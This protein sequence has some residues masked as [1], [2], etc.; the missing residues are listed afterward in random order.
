L[1]DEKPLQELESSTM[2][3]WPALVVD[4]V[5]DFDVLDDTPPL[6]ERNGFDFGLVP[7]DLLLLDL[8]LWN[9][10]PSS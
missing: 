3:P 5:V 10:A 2:L 9:N 4:F 8:V 7:D 6:E 1:D